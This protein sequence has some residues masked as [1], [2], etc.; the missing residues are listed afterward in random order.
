MTME[1]LKSSTF[2]DCF[3]EM[4][5]KHNTHRNDDIHYSGDFDNTKKSCICFICGVHYAPSGICSKCR[6]EFPINKEIK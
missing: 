3:S 4:K 6:K 5:R 2:L 1:D